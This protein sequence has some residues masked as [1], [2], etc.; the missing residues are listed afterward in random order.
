MDLKKS[1]NHSIWNLKAK[2]LRHKYKILII[3]F[4]STIC[5]FLVVD[6][7]QESMKKILKITR[8]QEKV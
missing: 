6:W 4:K 1:V 5:S 3:L 7:N 8:Y 2:S